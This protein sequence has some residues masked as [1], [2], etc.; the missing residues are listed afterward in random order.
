MINNYCVH[1]YVY[2][3]P[4]NTEILKFSVDTCSKGMGAILVQG[5]CPIAYPHQS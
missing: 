3:N 2:H 4:A 1:K 5:E